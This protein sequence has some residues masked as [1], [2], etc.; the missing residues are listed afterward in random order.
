MGYSLLFST[1]SGLLIEIPLEVPLSIEIKPFFSKARK[2]VSAEFGDLN[3]NSLHISA[4]VGG[5]PVLFI[6]T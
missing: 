5:N 2:C 3:P 6:Y 1:I 4:L